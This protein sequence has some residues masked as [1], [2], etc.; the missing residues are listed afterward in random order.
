MEDLVRCREANPYRKYL[1]EC[2]DATYALTKCLSHEKA[3][4]RAPKQAR[5]IHN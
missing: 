4:M 3:V 2:N 5:W 1:G